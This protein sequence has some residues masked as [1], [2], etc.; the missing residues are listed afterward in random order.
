MGSLTGFGDFTTDDL[1]VM[2]AL[3]LERINLGG[4]LTKNPA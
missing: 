4:R 2:H 3:T 1:E